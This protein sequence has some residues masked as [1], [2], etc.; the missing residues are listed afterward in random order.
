MQGPQMVSDLMTQQTELT[1]LFR[2]HGGFERYASD[3]MPDFIQTQRD[4]RGFVRDVIQA[5]PVTPEDLTRDDEEVYVTY[6]KD[7]DATAAVMPRNSEVPMMYVKG[8]TVRVGFKE[9]STPQITI[10]QWELDTQPYDLTKRAQEKSGFEI[11]RLEDTMFLDLANTLTDAFPEQV[12][13]T[14]NLQV[15]KADLLGIKSIFDRNE[16]AFSGYLMNPTSYN[17]FLLWGENDLDPMSQR[18]VLESGELPTIWGGVRMVSGIVVPEN[19]IYGLAPKEILGRMPIL[20]DVTVRVHTKPETDDK[21]ISAF[22]YVGMFIHSHNTIAKLVFDNKEDNSRYSPNKI[23]E[24]RR[25][26]INDGLKT[27]QQTKLNK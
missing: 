12:I 16:V 8:R 20:R 3:K 18:T 15:E 7:I 5:I 11:A 4:Y 22:E 14:T 6:S 19:V 23:E 13:H 26:N 27:Y 10:T 24:T 2:E 9:L 25:L 21:G 1:Q 17:D